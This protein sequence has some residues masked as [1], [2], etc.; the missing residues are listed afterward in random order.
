M[1]AGLAAG[2]AALGL[3]AEGDRLPG[4]VMFISCPD[5]EHEWAGMLAAIGELARFRTT[6]GLDLLGALNL[7]YAAAPVAY[8]GVMAKRLIGIYVLGSPTHASAPHDGAD[9]TQLAAAIVE[10]ATT[11]A[12]LV[13]KSGS[14][15]GPPA[16]ALRLR[17]LKTGYNVQT[18]VEATA[19][20]NL[21]GFARTTD[22]IMATLKTVVGEAVE[23]VA[24]RMGML[25]TDK[26][27]FRRATVLTFPDLAARAG[28]PPDE[29]RTTTLA[30]TRTDARATTLERV[31]TLVREAGIA[32]PAVVLYLLPP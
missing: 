22:E 30:P 2:A 21:M 13:E 26:P 29:A 14:V 23:E 4:D 6:G 7:D 5:E 32:A 28:V 24:R 27:N 31:R 20:L 11:S 3:L 19:E 12:A 8:S 10:R 9:A 17:D 25:Q 16:V 18:A 15:M 1:K